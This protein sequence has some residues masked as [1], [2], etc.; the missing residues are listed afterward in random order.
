[1]LSSDWT[2]VAAL[3]TSVVALGVA[4]WQAVV[5]RR[6]AHASLRAADAAQ[7]QANVA[8][9]QAN[10]L[11]QQLRAGKEAAHSSLAPALVV[12]LPKPGRWGRWRAEEFRLIADDNTAPMSE[13][14]CAREV[15]IVN[16]GSSACSVAVRVLEEAGAI[17]IDGPA[18]LCTGFVLVAAGGRH[19]HTVYFPQGRQG[20]DCTIELTATRPDDPRESWTVN[21]VIAL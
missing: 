11:R 1:M 17:S 18:S 9:E 21:H 5:G 16:E 7:V 2:S 10:L 13:W 6:A 14:R 19:A 12:S 4:V 3:A 20:T 8:V 15:V